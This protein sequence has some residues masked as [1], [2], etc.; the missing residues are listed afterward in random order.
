MKTIKIKGYN[1]DVSE[2]LLDDHLGKR[3]ELTFIY[4]GFK[5]KRRMDSE[6]WEEL[7]FYAEG[8]P[9]ICCPHIICNCGCFKFELTYGSYEI[10]ATC[11]DCGASEVVY[12]G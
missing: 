8:R 6:I 10:I 1:I 9:P 5:Y 12:D 4:A 2:E 3:K 7:F 11:S